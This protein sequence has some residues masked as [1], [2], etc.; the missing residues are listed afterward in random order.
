VPERVHASATT[1]IEI[2][3]GALG[4]HLVASTQRHRS[5]CAVVNSQGVELDATSGLQDIN[6]IVS[7]A[8][9]RSAAHD[10]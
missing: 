3:K 1:L 7:D 5:Q 4:G 6:R 8:L 10:R 2:A 9:S